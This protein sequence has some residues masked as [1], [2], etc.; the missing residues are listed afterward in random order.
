MTCATSGNLHIV[1]RLLTWGAPYLTPQL[2]N[3][4][5]D[6][7]LHGLRVQKIILSD[8][9]GISTI[10][11]TASVLEPCQSEMSLCQQVRR[12]RTRVT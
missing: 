1:V 2:T 12:L 4:N 11:S 8:V 9:N 7:Q 3:N 5:Q 10:L 6:H